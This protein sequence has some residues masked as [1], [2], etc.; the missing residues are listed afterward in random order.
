MVAQARLTIPSEA[1]PSPARSNSRIAIG[2]KAVPHTYRFFISDKLAVRC[3]IYLRTISSPQSD[4]KDF[5][6]M[7]GEMAVRRQLN[8]K[9]KIS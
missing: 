9:S 5:L 6:R 7:L 1:T 8:Q 2:E 4:Y 3:E